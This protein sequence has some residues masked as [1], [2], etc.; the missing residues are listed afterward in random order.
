M[1]IY[2]SM[3][4][5]E[6]DKSKFEQLYITYKQTMFYVANRILKDKYL[7]EDVV[8]QAFLRIVDNLS[9]VGKIDCHK[10]KR[11]IV[12][13]VE[14]IAID[15]YRKR[16]REDSIS[17]EEVA[18]YIED[19][20]SKSNLITNDIE[21]AILKLPINYS[22]VLRLKYSQGYNNKEVSEILSISE[23]NVRQRLVRG[24]KRLEKILEEGSEKAYE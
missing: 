16:K 24:R 7:S 5:L 10:T 22:A 21:E 14:N 8:H 18:I 1:M 17:F 15:F 23:E 12:V 2:L 4:E 19:I 20:K 9:K 6:E 11:F 3:I 13:I